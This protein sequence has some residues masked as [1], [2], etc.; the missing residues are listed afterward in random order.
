M[1]GGQR[2]RYKDNIKANLKACSISLVGWEK[3]LLSTGLNG[4]MRFGKE[5]RFLS[6]RAFARRKRTP[7]RQGTRLG[8]TK[9]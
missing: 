9:L 3:T 2:K 1:T 4:E 5:W 7:A 6:R 8:S